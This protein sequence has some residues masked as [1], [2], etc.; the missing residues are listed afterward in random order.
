MIKDL[1]GYENFYT[2]STNGEVVSKRFNK[3][4]KHSISK[5]NK[6]HRV[7]I[8]NENGKAKKH[9]VIR[10]MAITF[11]ENPNPKL[12]TNAIN[13]NG[14]HDDLRIEN[15]MWGTSFI[16][17]DRKQK[18][19]PELKSNFL[20]KAIKINSRKMTDKLEF[21]LYTMRDLGYSVKQLADIFPIKKSQIFE[22][23]KKRK[24]INK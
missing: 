2:I 13:K 14:N 8:V 18:R 16:S 10:L 23:L 11:L 1:K 7:S 22:L 12:Y 5:K 3:T 9:S 24:N 17:C 6:I 20:S 15:V 21:D 19:Y 4:L